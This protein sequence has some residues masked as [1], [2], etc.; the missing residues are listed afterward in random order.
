MKILSYPWLLVLLMCYGG[1]LKAQLQLFEPLNLSNEYGP[2]REQHLARDGNSL[3]L[4]WNNWG[5]IRFR[6]SDN[7][8]LNWAGKLTLYSGID[9]GAN[10]PVVAASQGKVYV[11]YYRNT[12]GN[13]QIFMV[14]STNNGQSFGNEIQVSNAIR[15]AIVPQIAA[16]GD[17]VVIAYEDRDINYKYQIYLSRSVNGGLSWSPPVQVTNTATAARWVALAMRGQEIYLF[18]NEQT[19]VN[20]DHLDLMFTKSTDFGQTFTQPYN[21]SQNKAYNARI[22]AR[23]IEQS[24]YV[25]VQ[26]KADPLQ[27][28]IFLYRSHN[29]G[30]TWETPLNL[31]QNAGNSNR[32]ELWVERN[33]PGNHRIYVVWSDKTYSENERAYLSFSNDHGATWS[34]LA[35]FSQNTEDAAWPGIAVINEG[36]KDNIYL[37]WNRPNDG[38]FVFEVWGRR[39]E[40][41]LAQVVTLNGTVSDPQNNPISGATVSLSG[42]LTFTMPD[43]SFSAEVPAGNYHFQVMAAGYQT[44]SIQDY[45]LNQN[46]FINITLQPLIP[47]N[48]PPHL[49]EATLQNVNQAALLWEPPIGFNSRELKYDDGEPNAYVWPGQATGNEWMAVAFYANQNVMLRQLKAYIV[50]DQQPQPVLFWVFGE[51]NGLPDPGT[52]LGGPYLV[53]VQN[54]GWQRVAVDIP[55]PAGSRFYITAQ[56]NSM[57]NYRLGA[58]YNQPDGFSYVKNNASSAWINISNADLMIRAGVADE[59][60]KNTR[61]AEIVGYKVYLNGQAIG[62]PVQHTAFTLND[63]PVGLSHQ[64]GVST[65][66]PSGES[67]IATLTLHVPEPLLF[68]PLNLVAA[69]LPPDTIR[70]SWDPPASSGHWLSWG[71]DANFSAVGGSAVPVFDAAIRFTPDDLQPHLGK[72]L[73]KIA[74]YPT[75]TDCQ[76]FLRVWQGGNQYYA[77]N[78]MR[79]QPVTSW[80]PNSWNTVDLVNPL[81]IDITQELW[82]GYRV[83][84]T[85]GGYPAGVDNGPAVPFKGDMLLYGANWV[86]MFNQFGWN[87]NWNLKGMLVSNQAAGMVLEPLEANSSP[88]PGEHPEMIPTPYM[89]RIPPFTE[90]RVYRNGELIGSLDNNITSFDDDASLGGGLYYL[91]S[92]WGDYESQPS[93]Q[94]FFV[95]SRNR[96]VQDQ[97]RLNIYPVPGRFSQLRWKLREGISA[98]TVEIWDER[99]TLLGRAEVKNVADGG[100][101]SSLFN[102][103]KPGVYVIKIRTPESETVQRIVLLP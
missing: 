47:G 96:F 7:G 21:I 93:N 80:V 73:T 40:N 15:G 26:A 39:A 101:V 27:S 11:A 60:G 87:I 33:S 72:Y 36:Q 24:L 66:Y 41:T 95:L 76:I 30:Q 10:Y 90:Y 92:A 4:V 55:I 38:T 17:T 100:L 16:S 12:A 1:S 77:G 88:L 42:Y 3:Y 102:E 52:L 5:D 14:R 62:E 45:P 64:I 78:L 71:S 35:Q 2:S 46:T 43:G 32:P 44:F 53:Q 37:V 6:K 74:F 75:A 68:P 48:Y 94:V 8:G 28:D 65:L 84:N 69:H 67:P 25:A 22:K 86:S 54:N 61:L 99:G 9:Y 91:T 57:N 89:Q 85:G 83:I 49:L 81:L 50:V 13:S 63:L 59:D 29:L 82:I 23:L 34:P 58:D 18:Y 20:Y 98:A 79:E 31:S 19:G 70:L 97:T 103:P 56:W 51:Q